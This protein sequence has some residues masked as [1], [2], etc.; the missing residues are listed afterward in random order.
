MSGLPAV[1]TT[2]HCSGLVLPRLNWWKLK[3]TCMGDINARKH[4]CFGQPS[5]VQSRG[6]SSLHKIQNSRLVT[7][8]QFKQRDSII[9]DESDSCCR[10]QIWPSGVGPLG[11]Q[12]EWRGSTAGT[13]GGGQLA[14]EF[15]S[16]INAEITLCTQWHWK[17]QWTS[18]LPILQSRKL[19]PYQQPYYSNIWVSVIN[20]VWVALAVGGGAMVG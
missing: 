5:V 19:R 16:I 2:M 13:S 7:K 3:L 11:Q 9:C 14:H 4:H 8:P 10:A 1:G 6:F 15:L 18:C 20:G 12:G 17:Q